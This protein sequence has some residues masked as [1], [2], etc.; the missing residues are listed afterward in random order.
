MSSTRAPGAGSSRTSML[1]FV[2]A[3]SANVLAGVGLFDCHL[4]FSAFSFADSDRSEGGYP[5]NLRGADV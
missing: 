4:C 5:M 1:S 3:I 2:P